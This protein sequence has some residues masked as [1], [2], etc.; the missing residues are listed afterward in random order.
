MPDK[1]DDKRKLYFVGILPPS[2][3]YE[4]AHALKHY[5]KEHFHTSGALKSPPHITLHM[6]FKWSE[7]NENELV[8]KLN[9]FSLQQTSFEVAF[10]NFD[11]FRPR[12]IFIALNDSAKLTELQHNLKQFCR[13]EL[14][15]P[16]TGNKE[17][18]YH[19][20]LTIAF[21]D[22]SKPAFRSAWEEFKYKKFEGQFTID[23]LVLMKHNGMFW[24]VFKRFAF[25]V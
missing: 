11:C 7:V 8:D 15:V 17:L 1:K 25:A 5:C 20:H 9:G 14:N 2:P 12:V 10:N 24:E 22:L 6:P 16:N 13:R 19:P 23:T 4:L 21:R 18:P 3:Y